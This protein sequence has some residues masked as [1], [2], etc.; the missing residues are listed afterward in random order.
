MLLA[1]PQQIFRVDRNAVRIVAQALNVD[2]VPERMD[3]AW[4][5]SQIVAE[6][7]R[8]L[9]QATHPLEITH[10]PRRKSKEDPGCYSS[11][12]RES[13]S[14]LAVALPIISAQRQLEVPARLDQISKEH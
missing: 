11:V 14:N 2:L 1:G 3:G 10:T 7:N 4:K 6:A 9:D 12:M 13:F 8:L 5:M